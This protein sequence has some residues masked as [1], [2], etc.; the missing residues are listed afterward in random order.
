MFAGTREATRAALA[1]PALRRVQLAWSTSQ[2][3]SWG[4]F[5]ALSVYAYDAGGASAV[6]AAAVVRR[7]P[8]ALAAPLGGGLVNR[9]SRRNVVL[10]SL[11]ARAA[12]LAGIAAG[13]AASA[14]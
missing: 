8:A 6:G 3:G 9:P 11:A 2:I 13:V 12:L 1:T 10:W 14:P 7:V 5:V 4:S